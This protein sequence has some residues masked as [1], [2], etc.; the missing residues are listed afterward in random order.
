MYIIFCRRLCRVIVRFNFG[1]VSFVMFFWFFCLSFVVVVFVKKFF[2]I[3]RLFCLRSCKSFR[4]RKFFLSWIVYYLFDEFFKW[5]IWVF[6]SF[7]IGGFFYCCYVMEKNIC[8]IWV[9]ICL[10]SVI[11]LLFKFIVEIVVGYL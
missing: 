8:F 7:R 3:V 2:W 1:W 5:W 4:C 10:I 9:R 6:F 11:L